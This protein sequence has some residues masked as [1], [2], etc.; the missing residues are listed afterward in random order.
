MMRGV[1]K[2]LMK[3]DDGKVASYTHSK[4]TPYLYPLSAD[5]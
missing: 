2:Y 1:E 5:S 4:H 3:I